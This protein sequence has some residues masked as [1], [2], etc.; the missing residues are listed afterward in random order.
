MTKLIN[1]PFK[2]I[3]EFQHELR[4]P[5]AG[6]LG[7]LELL[8]DT[9]LNQAER[10]ELIEMTR[11]STQRLW[12][13]LNLILSSPIKEIKNYSPKLFTSANEQQV[14]FTI[15]DDV[16]VMKNKIKCGIGIK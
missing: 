15:N 2:N 14:T 12:A 8:S 9:N 5:I 16:T 13:T 1:L 10:D 11:Q 7:A 6:A 3:S 4:I